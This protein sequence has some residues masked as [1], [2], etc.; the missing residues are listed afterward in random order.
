[1]DERVRGAAGSE[2]STGRRRRRALRA[3]LRGYRIHRRSAAPAAAAGSAV[4]AALLI[5]AMPIAPALADS[6]SRYSAPLGAWIAAVVVS[7][8]LCVL[9]LGIGVWFRRK[10]SRLDD[11]A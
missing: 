10:R 6:G 4:M 11:S 7:I 5:S 2:A 8:V 1:M 3:M 9:G